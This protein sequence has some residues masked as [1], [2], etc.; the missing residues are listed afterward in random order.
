M[1]QQSSVSLCIAASSV[2]IKGRES[3][4]D[5]SVEEVGGVVF[6]RD[7]SGPIVTDTASSG[8]CVMGGFV[9]L[10]VVGD[11]SS[12]SWPSSLILLKLFR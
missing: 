4:V 6:C 12:S 11:V 8:S 2:V 9:G 1:I 7:V 10:G 5:T 3:F